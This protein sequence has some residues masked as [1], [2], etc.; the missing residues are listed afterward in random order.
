VYL[1][2]LPRRAVDPRLCAIQLICSRHIHLLPAET[3]GT[4][5]VGKSKR[6]SCSTVLTLPRLW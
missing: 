6:Q 2:M 5:L 1:N 4:Y 3:A